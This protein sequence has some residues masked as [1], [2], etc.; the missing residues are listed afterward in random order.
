M[1][2]ECS[3]T[4]HR[5]VPH[6]IMLLVIRSTVEHHITV[7]NSGKTSYF[8][9]WSICSLLE[10]Q[11]GVNSLG[12]TIKGSYMPAYAISWHICMTPSRLWSDLV[13]CPGQPAFTGQ[14]HGSQ[15]W[16]PRL[17]TS[18]QSSLLQIYHTLG[19]TKKVRGGP[20]W[21]ADEQ[22]PRQPC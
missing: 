5:P 19:H 8:G 3:F 6:I 21:A 10:D 12:I 11:F 22:W 14:G 17:L 1:T 15:F 4:N 16:S 18:H 9:H 20:S 2:I 13:G 7:P